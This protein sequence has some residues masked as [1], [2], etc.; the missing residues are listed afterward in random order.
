MEQNSIPASKVE[1]AMRFV[2]T[3]AQ[4]G[5]NYIKH[6]SK[7]LVDPS[8]SKDELHEDNATDVYSA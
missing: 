6:Y 3:G 2:K 4:I 7:K 8:L 5:G 1:R